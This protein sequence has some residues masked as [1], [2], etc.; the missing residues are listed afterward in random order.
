M[1]DR[2]LRWEEAA[3]EALAENGDALGGIHIGR[4]ERTAA[5]HL[6]AEGLEI[7]RGDVALVDHAAG[8]LGGQAAPVHGDGG[9]HERRA[10]GQ[11]RDFVGDGDGGN[12]GQAAQSVLEAADEG[13]ALRAGAEVVLAEHGGGGDGAIRA[14]AELDVTEFAEGVDQ[15]SGGDDEDYRNCQLRGDETTA[16][17]HA[18]RSGDACALALAL[19][20][21]GREQGECHGTGDQRAEVEDQDTKVQRGVLQTDD[22]LGRGL[23]EDGEERAGHDQASQ[24]AGHGE[25]RDFGGVVSHQ[26]RAARAQRRANA[27]F[28]FAAGGAGEPQVGDVGPGDEQNAE[29][30]AEEG[31]RH[32]AGVLA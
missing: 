4:G 19:D 14:H 27:G 26:L 22:A 12:S 6:Y 1:A 5:E 29:D 13:I 25:Q 28:V 11:R 32:G 15:Q 7:L 21:A 10:G 30:G 17:S 3:G 20:A 9:V 18:A 23:A 8:A 31:P 2:V 24:P 16:Q